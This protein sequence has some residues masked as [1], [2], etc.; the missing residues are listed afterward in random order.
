MGWP[1]NTKVPRTKTMGLR[2]AEFGLEIGRTPCAPCPPFAQ[3]PTVLDLAEEL[4]FGAG[5]KGRASSPTVW[6]NKWQLCHFLA[7]FQSYPL[8]GPW[9]FPRFLIIQIKHTCEQWSRGSCTRSVTWQMASKG[10]E[11][12]K[13]KAERSKYCCSRACWCVLRWVKYGM[14]Q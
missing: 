5:A 10:F 4:Y 3:H 12:Q 6:Y 9:T 8:R 11:E 14:E 1:S 13:T 7:L 2:P